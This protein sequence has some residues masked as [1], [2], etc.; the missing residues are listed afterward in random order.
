MHPRVTGARRASVLLSITTLFTA[1][2][3]ETLTY[4]VD[5]G[6]GET[7]NV[8]LGHDDKISQTIA[9][10]DIDFDYD[11][12]SRRL[13]VDAI[14]KFS[15]LDYL[16]NAYHNQF[17]GRFDGDANL[18][19]IP[20]RLTWVL[21][22]DYGESAIDPFTPLTPNNLENINY[23]ATGPDLHLRFGGLSFIDASARVAQTHYETSP[24]S[25]TRGIG[26]LA[27]GLQLSALSSV[28]MNVSSERV[29]FDNVLLNP[30]F[31]ITN[32]F[33]R[34]EL[35]GGRTKLSADLGDSVVDTSG[36]STSGALLKFSLSRAI[37]PNARISLNFGRD[38]TDASA[39]F[40]GLQPGASGVV[41]AAAAPNASQSYGSTYG[42]A[43][44]EYQRNRT[45][46]AISGRW[47]QDDYAGESA[48]NRTLTTGEF[49]LQRQLRRA[50]TVQF[51]GRVYKTDYGNAN[52]PVQSG[53]P[54]TQTALFAAA[55]NWHTGRAID[56]KLAL[57]HTSYAT[58]PND[59]AYHENRV[60]L[61]VGY[62]PRATSPMS[63]R[64]PTR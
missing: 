48:F 49:R 43:G 26:S 41:G 52:V 13:D 32:A 18:A 36:R 56:V 10:T 60:F 34:Y 31:D 54:D 22:D 24:F 16:Q 38:K 11:E 42:S 21:Q 3:A 28:S 33:V 6:V 25:N 46:L 62:R 23:V 1:A 12:K 63:G 20:Q 29:L 55:L 17:V 61:T 27:W 4:G 37:S 14:G 58:S 57:E 19:L 15:Y 40:A 45:T 2:H 64:D 51:T 44:W 59:A 53:S 8:T 9:V 35:Q 47:E 7:D 30:D 50:F 5:A 39:S